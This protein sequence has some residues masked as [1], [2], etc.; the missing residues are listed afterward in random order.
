MYHIWEKI[1]DPIQ[2]LLS[3]AITEKFLQQQPRFLPIWKII[4][5]Y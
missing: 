3:Y 4:K 2:K 1:L 5:N